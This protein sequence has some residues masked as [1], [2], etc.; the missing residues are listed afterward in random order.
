MRA[1]CLEEKTSEEAFDTIVAETL[2]N[3]LA[4]YNDRDSELVAERL[5]NI[6]SSI[7]GEIESSVDTLYGGSVAKHTYVDGLSDIDSFIILNKTDLADKKPIHKKIYLCLLMTERSVFNFFISP[8]M[9]K[10]TTELT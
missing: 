1:K 9:H 7:Q 5:E 2:G 3:L 4:E 8:N 10:F 6:K